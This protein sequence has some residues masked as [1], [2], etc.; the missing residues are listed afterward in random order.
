MQALLLSLALALQTAPIQRDAYGVPLV[1]AATE[2]EA[3]YH[4]GRAVAED[5][6][7]QMEMS[8]R[9]ARARLAEV[10]GPSA[11]A[12]DRSVVKTGYTDTEI[13]RQIDLMPARVRTLFREYARGVNDTIAARKSAG[14]LPPGYAANGFEPEPWEPLDSAAIAINLLRQFGR[15]GAGELRNYALL[16]YLQGQ[17][18]KERVF[19]VLDDLAWQNDPDSV[20]T[21]MSEDDPLRASH[22]TFAAPTRAQ[23]EAH[24]K[25]LPPTNLLELFPAIQLA[26]GQDAEVIAEKLGVPHKVGSY[27]VV[28]SPQRSKTGLA[29]LLTAP[30]MGHTDPSVVH[31]VA[32]SCPTI[33]VAGIDVPGVPAVVI[34]NTP[35]FAWGLTSGVADIED[36]FYSMLADEDT[37]RYGTEDRK[38]TKIQRAIK[39]KGAD[40][41]TV[42][43]VRTHHGPVLLNSRAGKC[44]YSVQSSFWGREMSGI[45]ALFDLYDAKSGR[46]I[47]DVISRVPVTFNFF[48]ATTRGEYGYRYAGLVPLRAKGYDPRF[49]T[50]SDPSTEWQGYVATTMMPRTSSAKS[51]VIANWNNKPVSWWP[52][53]DT[54]VWGSP[55]RNEA[56][57]ASL[58]AGKLGRFDLER[59]AWEIARRETTSV[60]AFSEAFRT[61]LNGQL[62]GNEALRH[63]AA[64][65]LWDTE[66]AI[67]ATVYDEAVKELREELFRPSVGMFVQ[68]SIFEQVL[69]PAVIKKALEGKTKFD[70]LAGRNTVELIATAANNAVSNLKQRLGDDLTTWGYKPGPINVKGQRPIPYNNR[71]TYIQITELGPVPVARS[72]ASPGASESGEHSADQADLAR[73]WL[74]KPVWPLKP[75]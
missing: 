35:T 17:P 6:L 26:I 64:F 14:A 32:I 37:Y 63:L 43:V 19:D 72:V 18:C 50:P 28:V 22:P 73:A 9:A 49:P 47:E 39:V 62:D 3:F 70:Y 15:G 36:V 56:L 52:N 27:A 31:E 55:F 58:P 30:Q 67:G 69:Q 1:T 38:L 46:D 45:A 41:V 21:V 8:R 11:L 13:Q 59:A 65:D 16:L 7:W 60:G 34:G 74:Y 66:G 20:P 10:L 33:K 54:P 5:R 48:Y 68:P 23:T 53:L 40:P 71:G 51:G 61:A 24:V 75:D 25:A 4:F 57:L 44:V 42:D 12:S 2:Q 29:L